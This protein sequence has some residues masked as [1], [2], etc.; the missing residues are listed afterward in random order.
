MNS[1]LSLEESREL[2][3]QEKLIDIEMR[4]D[5][6]K[7]KQERQRRAQKGEGG[8]AA[9]YMDE[10]GIGEHSPRFAQSDDEDED[11]QNSLDVQKT[12]QLSQ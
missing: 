7:F 6:E 11:D 4:A 8:S 1:G 12:M 10:D 5:I 9:M 3:E 2:I